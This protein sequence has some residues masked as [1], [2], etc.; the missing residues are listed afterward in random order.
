MQ[1]WFLKQRSSNTKHCSL[2]FLF[3]VGFKPAGGI[4]SAKDSLVWLS[5]IKEELGDEDSLVLSD[6]AALINDIEV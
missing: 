2:L 6:S 4:R 5:L 3:Q 1:D